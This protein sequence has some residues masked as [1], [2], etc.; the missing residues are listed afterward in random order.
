LP[1]R[2]PPCV[3]ARPPCVPFCIFASTPAS[4][5][6]RSSRR[7][8]DV[9]SSTEQPKRTAFGDAA[10]AY[11]CAGVPIPSTRDCLPAAEFNPARSVS[12]VNPPLANLAY[13][14]VQPNDVGVTFKR[15]ALDAI[16]IT[17][18]VVVGCESSH[19]PVFKYFEPSQVVG[20]HAWP[21]RR[22]RLIFGSLI[23]V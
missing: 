18:S 19:A 14:S 17:S 16:N 8:K 5:R 6:T 11:C 3:A 7:L 12:L 10:S 21:N 1:A 9:V 23:I 4:V 13:T 15:T 20:L 2:L 22:S